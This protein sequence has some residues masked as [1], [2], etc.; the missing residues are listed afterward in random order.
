MAV[1]RQ[2]NGKLDV[3]SVV[4]DNFDK[5]PLPFS[6]DVL[7]EMTASCAG[8][9]IDHVPGFRYWEAD[10][11]RKM[12]RPENICGY[13]QRAWDFYWSIRVGTMRG[14]ICLGVGTSSI[15]GP[16]VLGVDKF[17]GKS[18]DVERYGADYGYPHMFMDADAPFPFFDNKF[19]GVLMNHVIEH[20]LEPKKVIKECLRVVRSNG[21]VGIITPDMAYSGRMCIDPTHIHDS[22]FCVDDFEKLLR[23]LQADGSVPN[24]DIV[25]LNTLDNAFSFDCI[26]RKH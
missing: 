20:L 18:P 3:S 24:F 15:H 13:V 22:E 25:T 17:C 9:V 10:E 14:G 1:Y 2:Q 4:I 19:E 6:D 23:E 16:S 26:L 12:D 21:I 7:R 11:K 5:A 8:D